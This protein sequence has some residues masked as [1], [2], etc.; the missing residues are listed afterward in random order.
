MEQGTGIKV[1]IAWLGV[2]ISYTFTWQALAGMLAS[3]Y[4]V[5]LIGEWFW[6][7]GVRSFCERHGWLKPR[8]QGKK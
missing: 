2:C 7:H 1:C 4:S 6:K 8:A 3:L 5:L